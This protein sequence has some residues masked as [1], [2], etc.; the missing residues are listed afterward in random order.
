MAIL[1][2]TKIKIKLKARAPSL[3]FESHSKKKPKYWRA[4]LNRIREVFCVFQAPP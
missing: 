4:N 3:F 2:I 1:I